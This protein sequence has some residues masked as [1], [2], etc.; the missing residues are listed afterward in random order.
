MQLKSVAFIVGLA[1]L[2]P[3]ATY[4]LYR[5]GAVQTQIRHGRAYV[6][7]QA[8]IAQ[9]YGEFHGLVA[10]QTEWPDCSAAVDTKGCVPSH[11]V[12]LAIDRNGSRAERH[13][14]PSE[15]N[16]NG[17][18]WIIYGRGVYGE[19]WPGV[20]KYFAL[21]ANAQKPSARKASMLNPAAG[22]QK[23]YDGYDQPFDA[24]GRESIL[25]YDTI[26]VKMRSPSA[27][28]YRWMAPALGCFVLQA[29]IT[30]KGQH[31]QHNRKVTDSLQVGPPPD[32]YFGFAGFSHESPADV[33][34]AHIMA[35]VPP[36]YQ[37]KALDGV[38]RR[39][40]EV[41]DKWM[42]AKADLS[43]PLK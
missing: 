15:G 16:T 41:Q 21:W 35:T 36:A 38:A 39:S 32:E 11:R 30:F 25:G 17:D 3:P 20:K 40:K 37:T 6:N 27:D 2:A 26:K 10:Q 14:F 24:V 34:K 29:E 19:A 7:S 13:T 33:L 22:C 1:L 9:G 18:Q 42:A 28:E 4:L 8:A 5:S 31:P 12:T 23:S 43:V